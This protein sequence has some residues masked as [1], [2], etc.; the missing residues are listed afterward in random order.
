[1][2]KERNV[3]RSFAKERSVLAF[4]YVLCKRMLHSFRSF[5]FFAKECCVLCVLCVLLGLISHQKLKKKER[6]RMLPSLKERKGTERSEMVPNPD[7][8]S[9]NFRHGKCCKSGRTKI[10]Q[11]M[12]YS[13]E[14]WCEWTPTGL[15]KLVG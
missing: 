4:F 7:L 11:S 2:K 9:A 10:R 5:T 12:N 13:D 6:K 8:K 3:L 15:T 14:S 1:M